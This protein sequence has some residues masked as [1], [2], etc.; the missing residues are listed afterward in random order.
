MLQDT[1]KYVFGVKDT[2]Q[3]LEMGAIEVLICWENLDIMRYK[4]KN[5]LGG[6]SYLSL[7]TFGTTFSQST[8]LSKEWFVKIFSQWKTAFD[9]EI[10]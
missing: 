6:Q 2:L 10:V 9:A 1:G 4:L 3:G 5:N 7:F 8:I